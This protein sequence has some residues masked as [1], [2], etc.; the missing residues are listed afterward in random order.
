VI[1]DPI[2]F[3]E[4]RDE[5]RTQSVP[6]SHL[7]LDLGRLHPADAELREKHLDEHFERIAPWVA[8]A[9]AGLVD[10]H[11]TIRP[12]VTTCL[13]IDDYFG[14]LDE[15]G[16][17]IALMRRVAERHGL[18]LDYLARESGC[19]VA[20]GVDLAAMLHARLVVEPTPGT[21][22]ARPP[23]QESGWLSNGRRS[24]GEPILAMSPDRWVPPEQSARHRHSIFVDVELTDGKQWSGAFLTAVWQLLRL[25][26]LRFEGRSVVNP[27]PLPGSIPPRWSDLP[28]IL[29]L[30]PKASPFCAHRTLSLRESR[31]L[32]VE[33]AARVILEQVPGDPEVVRQLA[34]RSRA[35]RIALSAD[36]LDRM[37]Y[38]FLGG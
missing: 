13:L 23:L 7:S 34:D 12:R 38:V 32:E 6:Y 24:P 5:P 18:H 35:E 10:R 22:G 37:D 15:P 1:S 17:L 27:V 9:R 11:P 21:T 25:G 8:A 29:Q 26:M 2:R 30:D 3:E 16:P 20:D 28:P 14:P 31:F 36:P 4:Q 19:V 33:V